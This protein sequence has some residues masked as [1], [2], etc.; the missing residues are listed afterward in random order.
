MSP[1]RVASAGRQRGLDG[2]HHGDTCRLRRSKADLICRRFNRR[3]NSLLNQRHTRLHQTTTDL[4]SPVAED[5]NRRTVC[6]LVRTQT[7]QS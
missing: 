1:A 5:H 6:A 4:T 2:S 3:S 7:L